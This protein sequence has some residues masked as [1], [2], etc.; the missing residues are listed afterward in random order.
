MKVHRRCPVCYKSFEV[1]EKHKQKFVKVVP[2]VE[3]FVKQDFCYKC[4]KKSLDYNFA[5][6][7][8]LNK[9]KIYNLCKPCWERSALHD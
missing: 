7:H 3:S 5:T 1:S 6:V 2:V 4:E 9:F 8:N